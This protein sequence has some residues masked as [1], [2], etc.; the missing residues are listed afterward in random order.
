[1]LSFIFW[2]ILIS[3]VYAMSAGLGLGIDNYKNR[4]VVGSSCGALTADHTDACFAATLQ[5]IGS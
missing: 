4:T 5:I 3:P 1:M 2:L